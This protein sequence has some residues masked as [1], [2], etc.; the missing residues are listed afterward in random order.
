MPFTIDS[1]SYNKAA[2][3]PVNHGYSLRPGACT[4][5]VGHS[6]NNSQPNTA[7]SGEANFLYTSPDVSAHFLVGKDGRIV[8]F[9]DVA[10]YQAWHAGGKQA[11]GTW[12]AQPEYANPVSFGIELH[13]ST[14]DPFYPQVQLD[15]FGWLLKQLSA[16]YHIP[17]TMIDTHGQIAIAGPY[18]RK[19]DPDDW[20]H[21]NFIAWRDALFAIDP[22][23]ARTLP[24]AP[25]ANIPVYCSVEAANFYAARGGL[26]ICGYPVANEFYDAS[27]DCYVLVCE[28]TVNKRSGQFGSEFALLAEARR[29]VWLA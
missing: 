20:P 23:R 15:A 1:T 22:L 11:N 29:E 25:P 7:F 13:K 9:L 27:L 24:G 6:T 21:A 18:I 4:S 10:K 14:P 19:T 16:Q 3:Y 28:R 2:K 5:G 17:P 12:T 8:Q 26:S